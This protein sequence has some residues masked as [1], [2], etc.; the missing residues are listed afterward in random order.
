MGSMERP[1]SS[2]KP[3][4]GS[5]GGDLARA[6]G[7]ERHHEGEV[8]RLLATAS[9]PPPRICLGRQAARRSLGFEHTCARDQALVRVTWADAVVQVLT[10]G[11]SLRLSASGCLRW[12]GWKIGT[13][14]LS[15]CAAGLERPPRCPDRGRRH[16]LVGLKIADDADVEQCRFREDLP[17]VRRCHEQQLE[18]RVSRSSHARKHPRQSVAAACRWRATP[19]RGI[20]DQESRGLRA[21]LL[22]VPGRELAQPTLA[23]STSSAA[24]AS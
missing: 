3:P 21:L 18:I 11:T 15:R 23:G 20:K 16:A 7:R 1:G 10:E 9:T 6:D 8:C 2:Q 14:T 4:A 24:V 5:S 22:L 13:A 12:R 19:G 17:F